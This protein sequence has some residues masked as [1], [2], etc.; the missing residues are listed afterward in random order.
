MALMLAMVVNELQNNWD[1]QLPHVEGAYNNSVNAATGIAPNEVNIGR[2]PR[3]PLTIFDLPNIGRHQSLNR[4]QQAY[5]DLATGRQQRAYR[6]VREHRAVT[7]SRLDLRNAPILD[8]LRRSLSVTTSGWAWVYNT[9][10]TIRQGAKKDTDATVLKT[11]FPLTG[12]ARSKS[13]PWA[14]LRPPTPRT[15]VLSTTNSSTLTSPLTCRDATPNAASLSFDASPAGTLMTPMT[16][17]STFRPASPPTSLTP[18][19]PNPHLST[20]PS[21][22]SHRRLNVSR[23]NIFRDTNSVAAVVASLQYSTNLI[24]LGS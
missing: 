16:Y 15:A 22:T 1:V 2:L 17:Q 6:I 7:V 19:R 11:S 24:G 14:P 10:A 20:S 4:D 21:T 23:S 3:L 12:L 8:A 5:S 18:L 9:A 13:S